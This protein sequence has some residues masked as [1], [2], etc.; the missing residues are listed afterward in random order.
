M[1]DSKADPSIENLRAHALRLA[2]VAE[3][4]K[5][6]YEMVKMELEKLAQH[7]KGRLSMVYDY[8]QAIR[9]LESNLEAEKKLRQEEKATYDAF[10]A[11]VED[12]IATAEGRTLYYKRE[13]AR[14]KGKITSIMA[15]LT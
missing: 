4:Y 2:S 1:T 10:Q 5:T 3:E 11:E 6:K 12:K 9:E 15:L 8:E 14:L 7:T 13:C